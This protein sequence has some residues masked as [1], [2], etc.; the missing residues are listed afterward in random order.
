MPSFRE[1]LDD[2]EKRELKTQPA[3]PQT[4]S[5]QAGSI[6]FP[7]QTPKPYKLS[8]EDVMRHWAS[9]R[10]N[11]PIRMTPL[12]YNYKGPT[13]DKDGV[14][15]TGTREFVDAV[16]GRLKDLMFYENPRVKL[17]LIYRTL[18]RKGQDPARPAFAV[19]IQSEMRGT[20]KKPSPFQ[21]KRKK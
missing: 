5:P 10:P 9:V 6:S 11:E 18:Y 8:K 19:Y 16:L 7:D 17:N 2:L 14:R 12:P 1:Y 15:V 13:Y 4:G 3:S 20:K 21:Q